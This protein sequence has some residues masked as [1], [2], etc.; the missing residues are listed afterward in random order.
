MARFL[1][2]SKIVSIWDVHAL[3]TRE[4]AVRSR[5]KELLRNEMLNDTDHED[6]DAA[7]D[8]HGGGEGS[9]DVE[10]EADGAAELG[11][12]VARD[13]K[14]RPTRR[15]DA[16]R[17][18]GAHADRRQHRLWHPIANVHNGSVVKSA[19]DIGNKNTKRKQNVSIIRRVSNKRLTTVAT[20]Y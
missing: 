16:V 12:Q 19:F 9:A 13:H 1:L 3:T 11:P 20:C 7:D 2:A 6:F 8:V 10:E 14:V 17:G 15:H 18:D 5:I 4:T